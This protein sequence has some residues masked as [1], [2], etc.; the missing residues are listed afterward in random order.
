M[1]SIQPSPIDY[2][3]IKKGQDYEVDLV[4][5]VSKFMN[6]LFTKELVRR[7]GSEGFQ[8]FS[9]HPGVVRTEIFQNMESPPWYKKLPPILQTILGK[10]LL[11][12]SYIYGKTAKQGAQT[13]IYCCVE[14]GLVNGEYYQD[15][16]LAPW[17]WKNSELDNEDWSRKLWEFSEKLVN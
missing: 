8:S 17:W 13:S 4:Y 7:W 15:C 2:T 16:R 3:Q 10:M 6:A 12:F 9:L 14:N 11:V 1:A 5:Q